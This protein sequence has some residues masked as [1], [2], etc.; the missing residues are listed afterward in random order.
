M[1]G[2]AYYYFNEELDQ[3]QSVKEPKNGNSVVSTIDMQIQKIIEQK[4][5]D[6]DDKIGSKVTNILVMNPQNGEIL[7]MASSYPYNLNKPMDEKSLLSLYSQNEI[8]QMKAYTKQK[9]AEEDTDSEESSEDSMIAQK[10]KQ[11][12]RKQSMMLLMNCGEILL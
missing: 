9:Q 12:T 5:K 6:F 4:L 2:R 1:N 10:R 7:G 11:M 8:D 3:E